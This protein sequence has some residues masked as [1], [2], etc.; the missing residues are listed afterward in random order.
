MGAMMGASPR[1]LRIS[2]LTAGFEPAAY[3]LG[4]SGCSTDRAQGGSTKTRTNAKYLGN[5]RA[6]GWLVPLAFLVDGFQALA[7]LKKKKVTV[8][9][10]ARRV[11]VAVPLIG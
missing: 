4:K 8:E 7:V 11:S 3:G 5:G 6:R 1:V 2:V 10:D 9:P